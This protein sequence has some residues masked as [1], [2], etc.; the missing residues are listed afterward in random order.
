MATFFAD[1][2]FWSAIID[3]RDRF[4]AKAARWSLTVNGRIVTTE[5]VLLETANAISRPNWRDKAIELIDHVASRE[6]VEIVPFSQALWGQ[7]WKL[8]RERGDKS[9]S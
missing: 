9:W 8:F 7:A 4:H 6:D 1:T 2:S 3:R 5:A